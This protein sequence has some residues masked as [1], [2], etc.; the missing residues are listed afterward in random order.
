MLRIKYKHVKDPPR[1]AA[2]ELSAEN[3]IDHS[4]QVGLPNGLADIVIHPGVQ[5]DFAIAL[6]CHVP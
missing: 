6:H 4:L 2:T 5:T 1:R 3:P